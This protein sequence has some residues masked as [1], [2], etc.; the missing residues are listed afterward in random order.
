MEQHERTA[1]IADDVAG[2]KDVGVRVTLFGKP[3]TISPSDGGWIDPNK[4]KDGATIAGQPGGTPNGA[5]PH[6]GISIRF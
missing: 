2:Y 3:L 1:E 4:G 5:P 6:G